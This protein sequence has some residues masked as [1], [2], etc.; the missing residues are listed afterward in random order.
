MGTEMSNA[1]ADVAT[2]V[3]GA[4]AAIPSIFDNA[5]KSSSS[6]LYDQLSSN[7]MFAAVSAPLHPTMVT[8]NDPRALAS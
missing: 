1:G 3:E 4:S 5:T 7:P 6:S 2:K 8:S